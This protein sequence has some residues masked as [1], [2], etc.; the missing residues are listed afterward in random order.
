[1]KQK[2]TMLAVALV[3]M[4]A[5][6]FTAQ[7]QT[8]FYKQVYI[9]KD[10]VK[11]KPNNAKQYI[12]FINNMGACYSSDKNG[13]ATRHAVRYDYKGTTNGIHV[14][15]ANNMF[16]KFIMHFNSD[17]SKMNDLTWKESIGVCV[18]ERGSDA[19]EVPEFY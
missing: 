2:I 7:A 16:M 14:Y 19:P 3:V 13:V 8:Y 6:S 12:T 4:I 18:Y 5:C 11:K 10:G 1:M 17:F 15:E 9:M